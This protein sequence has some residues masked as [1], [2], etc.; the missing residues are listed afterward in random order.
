MTER[1]CPHEEEV[2]RLPAGDRGATL[3]QHLAECEICRAHAEQNRELSDLGKLLAVDELDPDRVEQLRTALLAEAPNAVPKRTPSSGSSRR[4]VLAAGLC[5]A[6][7]LVLWLGLRGEPTE[8]LVQVPR[9]TLHPAAGAEFSDLNTSADRIL[10]LTEGSLLVEVERLTKQQ[11]VRVITGDAE[12][13]VRGTSFDIA[14]S[15]DRLESVWVLHGHV[16]VRVSGHKAVLLAQGDRWTAPDARKL[17]LAARP[18]AKQSKEAA[19][20]ERAPPKSRKA[21]ARQRKLAA[22]A[23]KP[24]PKATSNEPRPEDPSEA[25]F[26]EGWKALKAGDTKAAESAFGRASEA[27]SSSVNEDALF[28]RA[29]A[30]SRAGKDAQ[31]IAAFREFLARHP[32]STRRGEASTLLGRLLLKSGQ[33]AAASERFSDATNDPRPEVKR[34]AESG[35][36][37]SKAASGN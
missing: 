29:V 19:E 25:A 14:A 4:Y 1:T 21:S 35:L 17:G 32:Q 16:E 8:K 36:S 15:K 31:A 33:T 28:W 18:R 27:P 26:R 11:R 7:A 23:A 10:R 34:A 13:E 2:A 5:A 24:D 6:A 22:K 30:L 3:E 12:V 9:V 20:A 37:E